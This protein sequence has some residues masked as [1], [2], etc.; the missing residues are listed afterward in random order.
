MSVK[1]RLTRKGSKKNPHYR[2]V[3]ADS[4]KPRDG[5]FIEIVGTYNPM[6]EPEAITLQKEKIEAWLAKGAKPSTVVK[7]LMKKQGFFS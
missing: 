3:V 4:H 2:V 7:S 6:V 1:I 5:K